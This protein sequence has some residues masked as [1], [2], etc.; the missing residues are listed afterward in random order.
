MARK[1]TGTIIMKPS[2]AF[3]RVWVKLPDGTE[4]RRFINL[5]TT[6]R[7][8]AK[9]KLA[10]L[11]AMIEAGVVVAEAE[12]KALHSAETYRAYTEDR[13]KKRLA[14][15]IDQA[16]QEESSRERY[17]Y[18]TIGDL[19]LSRITDDHVR[20]I[21]EAAAE[22]GLGRESVHKVRALIRGDL[23]RAKREKLILQNV[24]EDVDLPDGLKKDRRPFTS[25]TDAELGKYLA[26]PALDLECKLVVLVSR[27]EGG[28]RTAEIIRW[29][30]TMLDVVDF[31][32]CTILRAKTREV[33]RLEIPEVLR[34]FLR[35]WWERAGKPV[36]GPVFPVRRGPRAGKDK[37]A[38]GTSFAFRFRR[39]FFR[40]GVVRLPP[41]VDA[42]GKATPNP[43]DPLYFDTPVSRVMT[44]HSLRRAYDRALAHAGTNIQTAMTLSGHTDQTTHMRYVREAEAASPVPIAALPFIEA[45][46]AARLL[47]PRVTQRGEKDRL[48]AE[49]DTGFEPATFSLGS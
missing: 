49:R 44:F 11:V 45:G 28:M 46:L 23:K 37:K 1:K 31:A 27:T 19:P 21:L 48:S 3:A 5:Q 7:T 4:E 38:R 29:E 42:K 13:H 9:R 18:A 6:D 8:T 20:Q 33:Q 26:A 39:D 12:A 17:V 22:R 25:P 30:W 16:P 24:A 40:A 14:S 32:S 2:G 10:K 41:V 43:A 36:A 15:G 35:A 34:P 47:S